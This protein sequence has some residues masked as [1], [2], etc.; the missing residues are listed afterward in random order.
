MIALT[1]QLQATQGSLG[2]ANWAPDSYNLPAKVQGFPDTDVFPNEHK[3]SQWGQQSPG[4]CIGLSQSSGGHFISQQS[5]SPYK[6]SQV[7]H[8]YDHR[9]PCI[10]ITSVSSWCL[11][12]NCRSHWGQHLFWELPGIEQLQI[13]SRHVITP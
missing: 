11:Q 3:S 8:W 2:S 7:W 6:H 10:R 4:A 9:S 13:G 1:L 5:T 12:A